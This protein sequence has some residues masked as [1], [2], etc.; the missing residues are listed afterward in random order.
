MTNYKWFANYIIRMRQV[1]GFWESDLRRIVQKLQAGG[2][3]KV[4]N[5]SGNEAIVRVEP[6]DPARF[7]P[8]SFCY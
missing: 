1:A 8:N 7:G 6:L 5:D 4:T 2:A 3:V